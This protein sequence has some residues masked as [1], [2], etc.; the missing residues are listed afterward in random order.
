MDE[1]LLNELDDLGGDEDIMDDDDEEDEN[2]MQVDEEVTIENILQKQSASND[3]K[4]VTKLLNSKT[5]KDLV[6]SI[7]ALKDVPRPA[8]R[9]TGPVEDDPEYK[10]LVSATHYSADIDTEILI[11]QRFIKD[12][13]AVK[14]P[15]LEGLIPN[16]IDYAKTVKAIGNEMDLMKLD[17]QLD[18]KS[19]LPPATVMIITVAATTTSGRPLTPEEL[20][21]VMEAC[22]AGIELDSIKKLVLE[23]IESRMNFIAPNLSAILGSSIAAKLMGV[24]GGL[25]NLSKIPACNVQVLGKQSKA[26]TGLLNA[27]GQEKHAGFI[28]YSDFVQGFPK[29]L[30]IKACRMISAK[31]CLAARMDRERSSADGSAGSA[32]R[33]D[34]EKKLEKMAEPP[35][36][37]SVKALPV[38]DEGPKKR[39]GG[40]RM[41]KLKE[42]LATS[43]AWKA[44]N[45]LKFGEAEE[46]VIAGDTVKG[47]GLLGKETG[48]LRIHSDPSKKMTVARKHQKKLFNASSGATSGLSSS[49]AFTP[50]QGI[51]LE[52]P[53]AVAARKAA[54]ESGS[55]YFGTSFLGANKK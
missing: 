7:T 23:Y 53:D 42:R 20:Q 40:R 17:M 47:M 49:L 45:R 13:Y 50:V 4:S 54:Q 32:M 12:K 43:E 3:L 28:Y 15:E 36:G 39:R 9:N 29:D 46:E 33:A 6:Q 16:A 44:Q 27:K 24:A 48:K 37:K 21:V 11:V 41:R 10:I 22:D 30:R 1:D 26:A 38:P 18:L 8:G 14:F 25:T 34:V 52:N 19:M 55:R 5:L 35:P 31:C 51:E 2:G